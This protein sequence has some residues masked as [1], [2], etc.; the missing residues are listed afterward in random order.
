MKTKLKD[1]KNRILHSIVNFRVNVTEFCLV[2]V[3][4]WQHNLCT[5]NWRTRG[6]GERA[7]YSNIRKADL[8]EISDDCERLVTRGS[9]DYVHLVHHPGN[10]RGLELSPLASYGRV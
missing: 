10:V 7:S 1:E 3:A 9:C 6:S 4:A 8:S 2:I 5:Q